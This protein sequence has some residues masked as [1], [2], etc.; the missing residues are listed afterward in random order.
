MIL[1]SWYWEK[2]SADG[3]HSP[4]SEAMMEE[5]PVVVNQTFQLRSPDENSTELHFNKLKVEVTQ[6]F[7][8]NAPLQYVSD[9]QSHKLTKVENRK[10]HFVALLWLK[11]HVCVGV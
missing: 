8:L 9:G 2:S 4:S 6:I 1:F 11:T 3:T 7:V 10:R 5:P